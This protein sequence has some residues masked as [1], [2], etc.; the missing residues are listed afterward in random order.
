[1][2][3]D[4]LGGSRDTLGRTEREVARPCGLARLVQ[5]VRDGDR[6]VE[7]GP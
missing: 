6:A 7:R 1:M 5:P 2:L 3:A 4:A